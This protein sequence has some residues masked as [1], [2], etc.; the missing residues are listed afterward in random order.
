MRKMPS[1]IRANT[2]IADWGFASLNLVDWQQLANSGLL[3]CF[4][5]EMFIRRKETNIFFSAVFRQ[6]IPST[7]D[8]RAADE[9][10]G[11]GSGARHEAVGWS[12]SQS[13]RLSGSVSQHVAPLQKRSMTRCF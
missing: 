8:V 7:I 3:F 2:V 11:A 6:Q 13:V 1:Y 5:K 12:V 10:T 9:Q 4:P